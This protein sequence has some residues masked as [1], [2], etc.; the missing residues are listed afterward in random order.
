MDTENPLLRYVVVG[1]FSRDFLIFPNDKAYID[2]KGGN[3]LYSA[4]GLGLWDQNIGLLGVVS[5]E[6]PMEWLQEAN[7][8]G[9]DT[10]GIQIFPDYFDQR[11]FIAY[12][13]FGEPD[14]KN[15]ISHF[16][17]IGQPFPKALLGYVDDHA[18]NP[19]PNGQ[20]SLL[21]IKNIPFDYLDV[22]AVHIC[23]LDYS[24][25][26][27]LPTFFRQG[28]ATTITLQASNEYM[29]ST[30][31]D[32]VPS[33]LKDINA[34]ICMETQIR[35]LFYGKTSNIWDMVAELD[36]FGCEII[37]IF[38]NKNTF[39]LWDHSSKR[40]YEIPLYPSK[41]EDPTGLVDSFCGGFISGLR[42]HQ[43]PIQATLQGSISASFAVEGIGPFYCLESLPQLVQARLDSL[44]NYI[45]EI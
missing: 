14:Y 33:I 4:A 29:N 37:I 25:Q 32:L 43:N 16:S 20:Q 26:S 34:F 38:T 8:R 39:L 21:K 31:S 41:M 2:V 13:T 30:Y 42:S 9:F 44:A 19:K 28:H 27:R 6:Y 7:N 1:K 17:R 12:P 18:R 35:E 3:A 10:R 36:I 22:T 40:K 5:E 11:K 15:P 45:T 24:L 23:S